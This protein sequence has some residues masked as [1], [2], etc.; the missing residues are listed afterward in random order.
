MYLIW[1]ARRV[2]RVNRCTYS[3][4]IVRLFNLSLWE[5]VNQRA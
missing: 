3:Q 4:M 1:N 5:E 2:T